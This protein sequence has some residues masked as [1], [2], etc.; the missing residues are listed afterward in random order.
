MC[1]TRRDRE[2]ERERE[3]E[4]WTGSLHKW[5]CARTMAKGTPKLFDMPN[6]LPF[7][8]QS[9]RGQRTIQYY[10]LVYRASRWYY[11]FNVNNTSIRDS[12]PEHPATPQSTSYYSQRTLNCGCLESNS[13]A[14]FQENQDRMDHTCLHRA[15]K[16]RRFSG[17]LTSAYPQHP[18]LQHRM[19]ERIQGREVKWLI[20]LKWL[21]QSKIHLKRTYKK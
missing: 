1:A 16:R 20:C 15:R 10:D 4:V 21:A 7:T 18:T 8:I 12:Y 2:R 5:N 19:I 11:P 17:A 14:C 13:V 9:R 3:R 6:K